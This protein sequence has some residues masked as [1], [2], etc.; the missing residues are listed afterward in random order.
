[1]SEDFVDG[2]KSAL[3]KEFEESTEMTGIIGVE[4]QKSHLTPRSTYRSVSKTS[5]V[6]DAKNYFRVHVF[7]PP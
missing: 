5:D 1:M 2:G 4:V 7:Y 6:D 3:E